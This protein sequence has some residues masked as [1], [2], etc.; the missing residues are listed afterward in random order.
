MPR[1][2]SIFYHGRWYEQ[3]KVEADLQIIKADFL[4]ENIELAF[5][6]WKKYPWCRHLSE[7]EFFKKILPYRFLLSVVETVCGASRDVP[8]REVGMGCTDG[9]GKGS[10]GGIDG[11]P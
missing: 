4:I 8:E 7:A 1:K 2:G 5:E 3:K 10:E 9:T 11:Y 6:V